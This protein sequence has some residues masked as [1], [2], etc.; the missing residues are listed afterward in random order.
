MTLPWYPRDMGKYARDTKHLSMLEHG[1]YNLMLDHY[2]ANEELPQAMLKQCSGNAPLMP[3]HSRI[4][5][6]CGA[7]TKHEQDAVDAVLVMFFV[8]DDHGFYRQ[9]SADKVIENQKEKHQKRVDA[10]RKGGSSKAMLKQCSSNALQKETKTKN[11]P[12]TPKGDRADGAGVLPMAKGKGGFKQV[13]PDA[14]PWTLNVINHLTDDQ[15]Q[16]AKANAPG[17]DIYHLI[18]VYE[19]GIKDGSREMPNHIGA[20][21]AGWC[22]K[23]TK[24]KRP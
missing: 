6:L 23:Y 20:A 1:A 3:D 15:M 18:E 24:G 10:G 16:K 19:A 12:P 8:M 13:M 17:W 4:Y 7:I 21:F 14:N 9:D 11:K 5:R 2:Y 22:A